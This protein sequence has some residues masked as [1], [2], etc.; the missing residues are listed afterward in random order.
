MNH[1]LIF[2]LIGPKGS[3]KSF[4]GTLFNKYYDIE[5]LRVENWLLGIKKERS[6]N[7]PEYI[8]ESFQIIEEGV[9]KSLNKSDKLVFESTGLS[10]SFDSMLKSLRHDYK[11]VTIRINTDLEICLQRIKS[12]DQSIHINVSDD[13]V[14]EIN[15]AI[16]LKNLKTE[17]TINNNNK[18]VIELKRDIYKIL[19]YTS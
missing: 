1:K 4:I 2:L 11:V 18:T 9:R 5:F 6:L 12:R 8:R 10:S 3:G 16:T 17:F 14:E 7:N 19:K 13:Q 15:T